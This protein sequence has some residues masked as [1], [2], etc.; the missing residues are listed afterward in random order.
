MTQDLPLGS[1]SFNPGLSHVAQGPPSGGYMTSGGFPS[2]AV[3]F[4]GLD[5]NS[6]SGDFSFM[7]KSEVVQ[8][9]HRLVQC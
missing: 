4:P 8:G 5:P 1:S 2:T 9:N 6:D 7:H 3:D